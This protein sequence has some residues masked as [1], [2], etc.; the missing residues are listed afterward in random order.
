MS[1]IEK[2]ARKLFPILTELK[3]RMIPEKR[4]PKVRTDSIVAAVDDDSDDLV[5]DLAAE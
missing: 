1:Y 5:I 3:K 4:R 2:T